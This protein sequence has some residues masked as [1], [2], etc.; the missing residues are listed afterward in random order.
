MRYWLFV[1]FSL[2]LVG[3]YE[4]EEG[5][6][7]INATNYDVSADDPCPDCCTYPSLSVLFQ[8]FVTLATMP[9]TSFAMRYGTRYPS[10]MDTNHLFYIDR[11]RFFVSDLKL[12]RAN[13]EELGVLDSVLLPLL[14]GDS[15]YVE[16][17][18]S[19]HDRDI[20]Q[21]AKLG[22]FNS[23]GEFTGVKFTLGLSP[24]IRQ[25][26]VDTLK[27]TALAVENDSLSYNEMVGIMPV[28]LIL[29][30]DTLPDTTPIDL[31]FTQERQ[32]SL[33][34]GQTVFVDKGFK[35]KV[36]LRLDY[37]TLFQGI[38]FKNDSEADIWAKIDSQLPNAFSAVSLK[39]E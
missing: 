20:F 29:R 34:F 18:Y 24:T 26:W 35:V 22:T 9:D 38:D 21:A 5:C 15:I 32:I 23:S 14:G 10:P 19:K 12:V 3:C 28:H 4:P 27:T 39:L 8:H 13:G 7:D 16:N 33:P 25:V 1:L 2:M 36:T 30:R 31:V 17:N 37:M 6:L 11:G